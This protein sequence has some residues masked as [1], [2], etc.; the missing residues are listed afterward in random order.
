MYWKLPGASGYNDAGNVREYVDSTTRA[1][2]TR[3]RS[4]QGTKHVD[5]EQT[6]LDHASFTF[7]LDEHYSEQRKLLKLAADQSAQVQSVSEGQSA[8][9]DAVSRGMWFEIGSYNVANIAVTGSLSGA[10]DE[11]SDYQVDKQNGRIYIEAAGGIQNGEDLNI[12]FDR[13]GMS[14]ERQQTQQSPLF[15]C[16]VII[17]EHNQF[18]KT[19]LRQH[20][21]RGFLNV[22]EFPQHTGEFGIYRIKATV[23]GEAGGGSG[24]A[25]TRKRGPGETLPA[26]VESGAAGESSSSSRSSKS[27]LSSYSTGSSSSSYSSASTSS[28]TAQS[29]TSSSTSQSSTTTQSSISSR[30]FSSFTSSSQSSSSTVVSVTT[31]SSYSTT[32]TSLSSL[33]SSSSS[34]STSSSKSSSSSYSTTSTSQSDESSSSSS[35]SVIAEPTYWEVAIFNIAAVG[36]GYEIGDVLYVAGGIFTQQAQAYVLDVESGGALRRIQALVLGSYTVKPENSVATTGGTGTGAELDLDWRII[37]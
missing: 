34:Y 20:E 29:Y 36:S 14:L 27:S 13:P 31:S 24:R 23:A 8:S 35:S 19:W 21:F 26:R 17:E 28:S 5:D 12:T 32:S 7:L 9:V 16:D 11:G 22:V 10:R 4:K 3:T 33:S 30:E 15:M 37:G 2:V 1:L 25:R 6:D 18:S